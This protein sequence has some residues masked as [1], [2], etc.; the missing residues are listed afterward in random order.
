MNLNSKDLINLP[1]E[2]KSGIFLGKV[3]DFELETDSGIIT[4]FYVKRGNLIEGLLKREQLI[5]SRNQVISLDKEKMVV[6]DGL[7]KAEAEAPALE[8]AKSLE[9]TGMVVTSA[10]E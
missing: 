1:V 4:K 10:K 8:K 6:E 2:T 3:F 9:E 5:I 7:I